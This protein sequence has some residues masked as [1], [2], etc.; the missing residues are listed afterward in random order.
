MTALRAYRGPK[1]LSRTLAIIA[2]TIDA[3]TQTQD[4]QPI[5]TTA[6]QML[7]AE[8]EQRALS[9][10]IADLRIARNIIKAHMNP[11]LRRQA[12]AESRERCR[13]AGDS[14]RIDNKGWWPVTLTLPGGLRLKIKTPY[15]L[16]SRK[17]MKGRPRGSGKRRQGGSGSYPVLERLGLFAA[18][19]PLTRSIVSRQTV[20]CSSYAEA[21]EQLA[22][23]GLE[24]CPDQLVRL[25]THVG[26]RA[27]QLR[28]EALAAALAG[29]LPEHSM[30][31]GRRVRI[32][33]DGGR[34]RTRKTNRRARKRKNGRRPFLLDWR[35]PRV[36]TIDVLDDEGEMDRRWR[37]I[38]EVS[39][40]DADQVFDLLC[41]LLRLI[42]AHQARQVVFVCD[43]AE[44]IWN[45]AFELFARAE[46]PWDRVEL[47]LD[48]YHATEYIADALK[49]CKNLKAEQRAAYVKIFSKELL[50]EGGPEGVIAKLRGFAKGRRGK[51]MNKKI[52]Y[53]SGHQEA[54]RLRY[55]ELRS[56][57]VPIGSG[58]VESTV[59]RVINLRFKSASQCWCEETAKGERRLEGLMYLRAIL[60]SG[61]WD[62]A[63]EAQ[64]AGRH[65]LGTVTPAGS[66][67]TL[68]MDNAA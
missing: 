42:G 9:L 14:R 33:V 47:V 16:P 65:F 2:T 50:E 52:A 17:G 21:R 67:E 6:Q 26:Q 29:P 34:T 11:E 20:L 36:I 18:A 63:M 45:R 35:E 28:D 58:I 54:G 44:W 56:M 24:L 4:E 19:T 5:P 62:E 68:T 25:A 59:R 53:L 7:D 39:L 57:K 13:E 10:R 55:S 38:Y 48:Y 12:A 41:G 30:V 8:L 46:V 15:L 66:G 32:C 49:L 37:P 51:A 22:R 23:D 3:L 40:G 64:L 31:A 43:G 1:G 27:L 61:R 60:K